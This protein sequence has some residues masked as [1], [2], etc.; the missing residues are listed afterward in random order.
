MSGQD[1]SQRIR[2]EAAL[3]VVRMA[4]ASNNPRAAD[5]LATW[6]Q[7]DPRHETAFQQVQRLWQ[8]VTPDTVPADL[9]VRRHLR[10]AAAP[11]ALLLGIGLLVSQQPAP[12][13]RWLADE[14]AGTGE[15]RQVALAD[16]SNIILNSGSAVNIRIDANERRVTLLAGDLQADVAH[17][18]AGRPFI[19]SSRDGEA[20]ALGTRYL[21]SQRA[22]DTQVDV[23]ESRVQVGTH[24]RPTATALLAAGQ[25]VTMRDGAMGEVH[26][27][28]VGTGSWISARLIFDNAPLS[29]VIAELSRHHRG[30]MTVRGSAAG[31]RFT[32][33]L[34]TNDSAAAL[35]LIAAALPVRIKDMTPWLTWVEAR[36]AGP[37]ATDTGSAEK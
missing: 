24:A 6:L 22:Q 28:G 15:I 11:L 32:G 4:E 36:D 23:L 35:A 17:D 27:S 16:G 9:P 37:A 8:A 18:P 2:E 20:R 3:W 31:L 21:V 13:A 29:E 34:P 25:S 10:R 12:V 14:R 30:L 26:A 33:A 5:D 1:D 7:A 19:V